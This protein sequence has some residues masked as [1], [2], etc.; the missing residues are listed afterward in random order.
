MTDLTGDLVITAS[1]LLI[2]AGLAA[3]SVAAPTAR[4][5]AQRQ[6]RE[7]LDTPPPSDGVLLTGQA[8]REALGA[9]LRQ[10]EGEPD[11]PVLCEM[12]GKR[13]NHVGLISCP[14][15]GCRRYADV[16][17]DGVVEPHWTKPALPLPA[18]RG[19]F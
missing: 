4:R 12:S 15:D 1:L 18:D 13:V 8:G 17:P 2:L 16:D 10:L 14:G 5:V 11:A 9:T 3:A 7:Y 6:Y 19:P